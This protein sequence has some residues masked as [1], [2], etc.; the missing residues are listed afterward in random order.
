MVDAKALG[1]LDAEGNAVPGEIISGPGKCSPGTPSP[2]DQVQ[3]G[4][5]GKDDSLTYDDI[6]SNNTN[7]C[8]NLVGTETPGA[9]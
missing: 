8:I 5:G 6:T 7:I 4:M 2:E 3:I 9:R 1:M